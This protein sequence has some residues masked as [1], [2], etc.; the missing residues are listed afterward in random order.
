MCQRWKNGIK[1]LSFCLHDSRR[2]K[3]QELE[4]LDMPSTG[5]IFDVANQGKGLQ[6]S[7][8]SL[9]VGDEGGEAPAKASP[10]HEGLTI[11]RLIQAVE[12]VEK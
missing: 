2:Q 6:Q 1:R 9:C 7:M 12:R 10:L 4:R 5:N 3:K 11:E 8:G